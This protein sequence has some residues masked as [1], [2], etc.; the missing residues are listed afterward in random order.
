MV[1]GHFW[2]DFE[3]FSPTSDSVYFTFLRKP[4]SRTVSHYWFLYQ[5]PRHWFYKE[6]MENNYT[7]L[8]LYKNGKVL[9]LDNCMI[10]FLS[11]NIFKSWGE[12]NETDYNIA[13][14]NFDKHFQH[15]GIN[16]Y[17]DES[18]LIL[19]KQLG[20]KTPN[21]A[22][23]NLGTKKKNESFDKETQELMAHYNQFDERLYQ[24]ALAKFQIMLKENAAMLEKEL[25]AYREKNKTYWTWRV[26]LY[27]Y[28]GSDIF[29]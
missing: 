26:W 16:E 5:N 9:N 15:F 20:W 21:Y 2:F 22:R 1:K 10:R 23:L 18:L 11:G 17:Y 19:A 27:K 24:H 12:I 13:K 7:L 4:I 25:P 6:M 29:K 8:E 28:I 14:D 3:R